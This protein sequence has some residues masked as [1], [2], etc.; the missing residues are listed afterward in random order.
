[1]RGAL[2]QHN[3]I[4]VAPFLGIEPLA[5][6]AILSQKL[7]CGGFRGLSCGGFRGHNT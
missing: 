7:S 5:I 4:G 6:E 2:P 1:M 3:I